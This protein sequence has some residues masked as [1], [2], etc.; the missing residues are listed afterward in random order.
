MSNPITYSEFFKHFVLRKKQ[1]VVNPKVLGIGEVILPKGSLLHFVPKTVNEKGPGSSEAFISN[2]PKEVFI[3]FVRDGYKPVMGHGRV[4]AYDYPKAVKA[5]RASHYMYS[6]VRE[7]STVYNKE[8]VLVVKNYGMIPQGFVYRPSIFVNYEKYYNM[9]HLLIENINA[10]AEK[11][12][13]RQYMRIDLPLNLPSLVELEKDYG[14][15]IDGFKDGYPVLMRNMLESTKA[16]NCY[17]LL[18]LLG[19]LFG[20]YSFSLFG[21]LTDQAYKDLHILF[22]SQSKVIVV[23]LGLLKGWLDETNPKDE[24][25]YPSARKEF[26]SLKTLTRHNAVKR[27]YLALMNLSRGGVPENVLIKEETKNVI[28]IAGEKGTVDQVAAGTSREEEEETSNLPET[29]DHTGSGT[30]PRAD[31]PAGSILDVFSRS[32]GPGE[33]HDEEQDT[34]GERGAD[35]NLEEWT[36]PVDDKLLEVE[37]VQTEIN[38]HKNVFK[39]P[40]SGVKRALEERAKEGTLT[41]AEHD[42]FMRKA[43]RYQHIEMENGQTFEEFIQIKPEE[44]KDLGGEIE[45][46][47]LPVLDESM[48]RSRAKSLK[49]EY[50]QKFLHRDIGRMVLGLQNAGFAM[51][52]YR[53][54]KVVSVEGS[55][56]VHSIQLHEVNGDQV[57]VH[58]R[59]PTVLKDGTYVIDGVKQHMQLQRREKPFRKISPRE[60]VL[61]SYYDRKLMVSRS[62]KMVDNLSTF[63]VKQISLQSKRKGYTVTKGSTWDRSLKAPRIYSILARQYKYITVDGLVLDFRLK[64]L[65][66][67]HPEFK[68]YTRP[69]RFLIGVKDGLPL[70]I[71]DYGNLYKGEEELGTVEDLL[72]IDVRKAPLEHVVINI[73]GYSFPLGVVLCFYFGIDELL[74]VIKATTRSVPVGTRPKLTEDEYAIQ[75]N[76]EYLIFNRR[77]KL[78]TLIFGGMPKLNNISNFSRSDLN[79]NSIWSALMGD[80]R[81]RPSQFQEMKNLFDL[82]IDPITKDLLKEMKLSEDFHYLLIDAAKALETDYSRHEV[83]IEEQRIVGYE[84]FAGHLYTEFV[85]SIRQYRNKG[86]GRKHKLDFNPDAVIIAI[87]TDRS[88]NLVEEVN[89]VHQVKDQ[90]EVTF[91]GTGGR[92]EITMVKRA[93]TQLESYKGVISEANKDSGKVGYV[94]YTTSDPGI[95][96][97]RGNVDPKNKRTPTGDGSVTMNLM[98]GGTHDDVKRA[99]FTSTQASQAVMAKNYEI[100]TLRTG[101]EN[102][103]A[104][105]TSDLYSKVAAEDGKVTKVENDRLLVEYKDGTTDSYPLGLVIGEASGEY[106][107]H[108][109]TT[110]LKVGDTFRKGDVIGW[111]ENW[112]GRDPFCPGQVG[113]KMGKMCQIVMV[114][115]QDV[116]EDS[117]A[118]SKELA[119]EARTPFIKPSRFAEDVSNNLV[120][121]VK[122]GDYVEQDTILCDIEEPHLVE[123]EELPELEAD[124]NKLGIKQIRSKHHGKIVHI[125]VRYNSPLDKMSDSFRSFIVQKDKETKRKG[126]VEGTGVE[127]NA[128]STMFNLNRPM[129]GPGKAFITFY[130]E[131]L[132]PSTNADKY[133]IGNQMKATVGRIMERPLKTASGIVIDVKSSFKGMFNRMVLSLRNKLVANEYGYQITRQA[134]KLYRGK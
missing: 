87:G 33:A 9:M 15:F 84:R 46:E 88:T 23:Q 125:D 103:L 60:V 92:S 114:E 27:F 117:I 109:R 72:G 129:L 113:V 66:E 94:T 58:T 83:E 91:G 43:T 17:W 37:K 3:E 42:F 57:T 53:R 41:V 21:K 69:D 134:I 61:S 131:S 31:R 112:F 25:T 85:K 5:Y 40:E 2:F 123:G 86:K 34:A 74:R 124:I 35:S 51:N 18:D 82:F 48:L 26:E 132:D 111:D 107:P 96:D 1:D 54:E 79:N 10:E 118:I 12:V 13:R 99:V 80:P 97:F 49:I 4:V 101:Y 11:G 121:R 76:D 122:V 47:F 98:Y 7:I 62:P 19:F 67:L 130:I 89:P 133:V 73:S 119:M 93:R 29:R 120:M 16:E 8:N 81:V 63:M 71:D 116:Y 22:T 127:N 106:H 6:W 45:G 52:D 36:S 68:A 59:L 105:R 30:V 100:V 108:N 38:T 64:D 90:E 95:A 126:L 110:D 28:P 32:E 56:E 20:Q 70:I 104:H 75:F 77:E 24:K 55:Y 78:T 115:D 102:V 39:T 128:I 65:L 44:V 14:R 50:P